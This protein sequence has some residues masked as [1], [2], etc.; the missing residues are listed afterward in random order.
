MGSASFLGRKPCKKAGIQKFLRI[1]FMHDKGHQKN[2][3]SV[4][5]EDSGILPLPLLINDHLLIANL[6][7]MI[8]FLLLVLSLKI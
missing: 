2:F 7:L 6:S 5:F 1:M 8:I 4:N 3:S